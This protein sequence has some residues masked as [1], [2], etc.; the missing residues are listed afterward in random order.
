[1]KALT[2]LVLAAIWV[3]VGAL[4]PPVAAMLVVIHLVCFVGE[5]CMNGLR[6]AEFA[7]F[8]LGGMLCALFGMWLAGAV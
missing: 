7:P 5:G 4:F 2:L 8:H 6:Y 1:M 3:A